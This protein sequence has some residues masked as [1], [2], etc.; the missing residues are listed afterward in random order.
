MLANHSY[1]SKEEVSAQVLNGSNEPPKCKRCGEDIVTLDHWLLECPGPFGL[2][3]G[4]EEDDRA[5]EAISL[6]DYTSAATYETKQKAATS[7]HDKKPFFVA[8][9]ASEIFFHIGMLL[10]LFV[11]T[12]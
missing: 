9:F 10:F 2:D 6:L 1:S 4:P 3:G 7:N 12:G 11:E 8:D 5:G